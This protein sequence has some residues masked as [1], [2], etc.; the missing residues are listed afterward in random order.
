MNEEHY[1][2]PPPLL[3]FAYQRSSLQKSW[4]TIFDK[5]SK[6]FQHF[7]FFFSASVQCLLVV[8]LLTWPLTIWLCVR[9][10]LPCIILE[11]HEQESCP[12]SWIFKIRNSAFPVCLELVFGEIRY[13]RVV[14]SSRRPKMSSDPKL[15]QDVQQDLHRSRYY[16]KRE[17]VKAAK[18]LELKAARAFHLNTLANKFT[19]RCFRKCFLNNK[20][21]RYSTSFFLLLL[22]GDESLVSLSFA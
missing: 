17:R 10:C 6:F 12:P 16:S 15:F 8:N 22:R 5:R 11:D 18:E 21:E 14:F 3:P 19:E 7:F 9:S 2:L 13:C 20:V 4:S 1:F